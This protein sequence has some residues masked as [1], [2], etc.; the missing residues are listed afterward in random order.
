[1]YHYK[2]LFLTTIKYNSILIFLVY[3]FIHSNIYLNIKFH[4]LRYIFQN[5]CQVLEIQ[6]CFNFLSWSSKKFYRGKRYTNVIN[7]VCVHAQWLSPVQ[8]HGLQP[9]RFLCSWNLP[10]KNTGVGCHFLFQGIFPT[11]GSNL[12]LLGLLHWQADSLLLQRLRSPNKDLINQFGISFTWS[13]WCF[14][15]N[16]YFIFE[17]LS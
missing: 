4:C 12:R 16:D 7:K 13:N 5:L 17:Y 14:L 11:Q 15:S 2:F 10:G 8:L 1:M 3:L 6:K 9:A